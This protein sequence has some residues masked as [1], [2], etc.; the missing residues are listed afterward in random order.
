MLGYRQ[1]EQTR[2]KNSAGTGNL[3]GNLF[4]QEKPKSL[5]QLFHVMGGA[6]L[7]ELHLQLLCRRKMSAVAKKRRRELWLQWA[8]WLPGA[9]MLTTQTRF[10][11]GAPCNRKR[12]LG[13]HGTPNCLCVRSP[14]KQPIY[15]R[16]YALV[17]HMVRSRTMS[18]YCKA[19]SRSVYNPALPC[20]GVR[21]C[22]PS[23]ARRGRTIQGRATE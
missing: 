6:T 22:I 9:S 13:R 5:S 1:G 10:H 12:G 11:A 8:S 19:F 20:G 16:E 15:C 18:T 23:C 3:F 21:C 14:S 17:K 7:D 2:T 4:G